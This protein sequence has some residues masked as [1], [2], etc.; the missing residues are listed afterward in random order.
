M[1][2][3]IYFK[4]L[5]GLRALAALIVVI[6]HTDRFSYLF[7][8]PKIG[9]SD[10][11]MDDQAVNLFFVLSG[12]LITYLLL[13]EKQ[14]TKTI[15]LRKF[16]FRRILRIW[17]LYY[18]A[19]TLSLVMMYFGVIPK[20][21]DFTASL[22]LYL[23]LL[24]NVAYILKIALHSI[25]PLWS[26]GV[27]EQFYLIWPL[28]LKHTTRYLKVFLLFFG[29]FVLLK[30]VFHVTLSPQSFPYHFLTQTRLQIMCMGA[31]GAYL[32]FSKSNLL[33]WV[34]RIE[35]QVI[36]WLVLLVAIVYQPIH[37]FSFIDAEINSFFFVLILLNVATNEKSI[38]SLE[39][40]F[41]HFIG[42]ISYGIYVYHL[43]FIYLLAYVLPKLDLEINHLILFPTI[44]FPTIGI[45][46]VSFRYFETPFLKM[47]DKYAVVQSTNKKLK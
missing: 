7:G 31:I 39:N 38:L 4:G 5:N 3:P 34:Y 37:V 19:L 17:P 10:N 43:M 33:L 26:V 9:F 16:Y 18:L 46:W 29:L 2:T 12:F 30:F 28:L 22:L 1:T 42:R 24:A 15:K 13:L 8:L 41:F 11:K 35:T 44:L 20:P 36:A 27:E 6:W 47:K 40:P 21:I 45:A 25:L 23:F 14:K 32:V